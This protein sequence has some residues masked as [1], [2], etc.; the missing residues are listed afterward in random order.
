MSRGQ[1][2]TYIYDSERSCS[3]KD[4]VVRYANVLSINES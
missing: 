1:F 4:M 2:F 3:S